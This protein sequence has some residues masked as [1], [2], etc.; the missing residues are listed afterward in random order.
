MNVTLFGLE[1]EESKQQKKSKKVNYWL[2][3]CLAE[4]KLFYLLTDGVTRSKLTCSG[5]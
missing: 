3:G 1:R 5:Q 2:Y 4:E